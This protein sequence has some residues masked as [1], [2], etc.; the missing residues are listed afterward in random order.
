[1]PRRHI[2][3]ALLVVAIWGFNFVVIKLSVQ[4]LPPLSAAGLRFLLAAFPAVF[5][6]RPPINENGKTP[7]LIIA[8]FGLS[9]GFG[10]YFFL[11]IAISRGMPAGLASVVLQVQV[12]FTFLVA[13]FVLGEIPRKM[14]V[15]GALV[16]FT[17]I[18][19]I[20][21]Y[22]LEGAS[23]IPFLL[24]ICAAFVWALA[25]VLT[26]YAGKINPVALAVWG[27][28]FGAVPLLVLSLFI[29]GPEALVFMF[30]RP[31][32]LIWGLLLFLAYPATLFGFSIWNKLLAAYPASSVVPFTLLVP[33][34][35]I[36]S[37]WAVLGETIAAFEIIGGALVVGGLGITLL[38]PNARR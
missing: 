33:I 27:S 32:P 22:R 12:F 38:R 8:G 14:Q 11:N 24:T 19:V 13:F 34:T 10:L 7:W 2:L 20:G 6:I 29:E 37:G 28:L 9:F 31:D 23:F 25:N 15:M 1:M 17:G 4:A 5:F 16:A 36:F 35:G 3:L 18:G 26:R 30:V 21:F